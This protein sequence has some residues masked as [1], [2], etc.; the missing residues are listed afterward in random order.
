MSSL[1]DKSQF[2][3]EYDSLYPFLE[4]LRT[5]GY[6]MILNALS[7][8]GIEVMQVQSRVKDADSAYQK[9]LTKSY[10][11]PFSDITDLV[12]FRIIVFLEHE[13]EN[14]A[15]VL[16]NFFEVDE[17]NSVDKR[18]P[19]KVGHMGYRSLHLVCSLGANREYL[20]E[21]TGISAQKFEI[22]IRTALQHAWAE[23]E[24]KR[25]YKSEGALPTE[26][27]HR[28]MRISGTLEM[29][30]S[31]FSSIATEAEEYAQ[32]VSE[33]TSNRT[34]DEDISGV[35]LVALY[36]RSISKFF[37]SLGNNL[38]ARRSPRDTTVDIILSEL[39]IF[40][41]QT[42]GDLEEHLEKFTK[43]DAEKFEERRVELN[44]S[45]FYRAVMIKS[46]IDRF[47]TVVNAGNIKSIDHDNVQV[48]EAITKQNDLATRF[49]NA[50]VEYIPF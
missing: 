50:G 9:I 19:S 5:T 32:E 10:H 36:E 24:H 18:F 47:F 48:L 41:V 42:I 45:R 35:A 27:Q 20:P 44:F 8:A 13:I 30:D 26:L 28:L 25:N 1:I 29:V 12:G 16:R 4:R 33:G 37:E 49:E 46:D 6:G 31:E 40:G 23:I 43:S 17:T 7:E 3:S 14:A 39:K 15:K 2:N 22:Q 11:D 38:N 21:Y 34:R